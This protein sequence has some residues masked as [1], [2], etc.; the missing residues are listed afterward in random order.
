MAGALIWFAQLGE[1]SLGSSDVSGLA[2]LSKKLMFFF[3]AKPE[4][5]VD[6]V[7]GLIESKTEKIL[8]L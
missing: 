4:K 1:L 2:G 3:Y 7:S 8:G 6:D 5:A